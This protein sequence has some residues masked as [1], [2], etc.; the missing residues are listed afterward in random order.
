MTDDTDGPTSRPPFRR[1]ELVRDEDPTGVSGTGVVARGV[2]FPTGTAVI[3]WDA[4][5][6][7]IDAE[8]GLA[9]KPG[10]DGVAAVLE[11]HGHD[12]A[13]QLNW[14]DAASDPE[15]AGAESD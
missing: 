14:L 3:E 2:E 9:I 10:P 4:T 13:T 12:G 7:D 6:H 15:P 5:N 1:F 8:N 11:V